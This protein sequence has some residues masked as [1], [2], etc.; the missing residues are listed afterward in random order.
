[1][2]VILL[3]ERNLLNEHWLETF[4]ADEHFIRLSLFMKAEVS[5]LRVKGA[6]FKS[7]R[8]LCTSLVTI[9]R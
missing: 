4:G 1:M 2:Q 7:I 9:F 5:N 8:E 3:K 6:T